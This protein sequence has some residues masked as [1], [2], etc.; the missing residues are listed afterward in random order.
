MVASPAAPAVR[1]RG[2]VKRFPGVV[3]C[4]GADLDVLPGE[5]HA[6]LGENGAGKST[7]M[8][9]LAGLY[10]PDSGE[11]ALG[12]APVRLRSPRDA[13]RRGLGMVHQH[14]MLVPTLTVAENLALGLEGQG[15][16]LHRAALEIAVERLGRDV[17]LPVDP[18]ARVW[19]LSVGEQQRVE[20]LKVLHRGAR[21]LLLDEPTAV[22]A[23]PEAAQLFDALRRLAAEGRSIV[24][25]THK[26][27]E[28]AAVADRATVLRRGRTVAAGLAVASTSSEQLSE[29]M[30][31]RPMG[32]RLARS[33]G[34]PGEAVLEVRGLEV[35]GD[36]GALAVRGVDLVVRAGEIYGLAGV[37]GNGQ[38]ELVEALAGLRRPAAGH[39]RLDGVERTGSP[40]A[41][42]R[43]AGLVH[44][45]EDRQAVGVAPRLSVAENLALGGVPAGGW[46]V[47][48]AR[49]LADASTRAAASGI[50]LPAPATVAGTLSGGNLQRVILARELAA[51]PRL[52]VAAQPTRGLD[53]GATE[54]VHRLLL[55]QR[56]RGAA[57]LLVSEDLEELLCLADRVGVLFGG[58][59]VGEL[60]APELDAGRLGR[61]MTGAS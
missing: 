45:P 32:R 59:L 28:V 26:L 15:A 46:W 25:I 35:L 21:V 42:V 29:H 2:I 57:V 20:I 43:A 1:L 58:R 38:R 24:L 22:L 55:D 47:S 39:V 19:Q 56:A 6:L 23:P 36:R 14:F 13:I 3:A 37:S 53:V 60:A 16:L 17:G 18:T 9:V 10:R 52:I 49:L 12:G 8:N 61:W 30:I 4:D 51:S 5:V 41:E 40:V 31:G 34:T 11:V 33:A 50:E 54:A 7:L 48:P 44:V 27:D